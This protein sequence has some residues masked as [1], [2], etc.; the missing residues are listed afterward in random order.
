V[1]VAV[2]QER[3][4]RLGGGARVDVVQVAPVRVRVDL[5]EGACLRRLR[6]HA[7]Q[8]ERV[9]LPPLDQ[10][11]GRMPDQVD[12]R[13]LHRA[14]HALGLLLLGEPERRVEA[15]DDPIELLEHVVLVVE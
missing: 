15:R 9:R 2:D 10:P 11:A 13:M 6:C 4:A 12:E 7:V 8:V 3:H 5:E 1:R 14:H